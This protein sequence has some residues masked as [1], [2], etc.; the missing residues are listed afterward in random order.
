MDVILVEPEIPPNTG[1]VARTCAA[2]GARLHLVEPLGFF[3]DDRHLRRAGVDYWDAVEVV[4]HPSWE[5]VPAAFKDPT[6][7]HLFTGRGGVRYDRA[8][9]TPDAVLVFGRERPGEHEDRSRSPEQRPPLADH[10][11]S[12]INSATM[13]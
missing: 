1:N 7:L 5:D 6:R 2:V 9:Y 8:R 13:R 11:S 4:V 10:V 3:L 12:V